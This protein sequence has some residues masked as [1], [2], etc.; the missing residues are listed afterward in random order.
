ML[1]Q[2]ARVV[3]LASCTA[4]SGFPRNTRGTTLATK[5]AAMLLNEEKK[6]AQATQPRK[7]LYEMLK[8][9]DTAMLV[10]R[11]PHG[12][13]HAR[14]M[15][16]ARLEP[17]GDAYF[18]TGIDSPKVSEIEA[19]PRVT[20]T[21][22]S[23]KQYATLCGRVSVIRDRALLDK[24]WKEPWKVWF[25]KGKDDPEISLLKFDAEHGELWDNAGTQGVK[26]AF[27]AAKAYAKGEKPKTD[28]DQHSRVDL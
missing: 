11:S 16:V 10:T 6:M 28:P 25:P 23:T 18:A 13:T 19:D 1:G 20:L 2:P 17:D 4:S 7:H 3:K 8:D 21:F 15:A 27:E 14:P 26:Y 5:A 9:F 24:L 12:H 22:Q